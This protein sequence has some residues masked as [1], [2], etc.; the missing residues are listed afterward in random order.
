VPLLQTQ[1]AGQG[2]SLWS[3]FPL[4]VVF[5][6]EPDASH[7]PLAKQMV[8]FVIIKGQLRNVSSFVQS[9]RQANERDGEQEWT[10]DLFQRSLKKKTI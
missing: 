2:Y 6:L 9:E 4:L 3:F 8:S 5:H 10:R 7:S 1:L